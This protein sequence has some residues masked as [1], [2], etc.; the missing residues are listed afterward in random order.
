MVGRSGQQHADDRDVGVAAQPMDDGPGG[1]IGRRVARK[2]AIA[3]LEVPGERNRDR[4]AE[5][6]HS[7]ERDH[8]PARHAERLEG[9][10]RDLEQQPRDHR[11][12]RSHA[13]DAALAKTT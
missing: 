2:T 6:G 10:V 8:H 13:Q 7:D 11:V 1:N 4:E 3:Q 5:H 12:A 9:H